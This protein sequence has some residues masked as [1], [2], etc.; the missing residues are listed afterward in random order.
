[1]TAFQIGFGMTPY[2]RALLDAF[3]QIGNREFLAQQMASQ[4]NQQ[5]RE[6]LFNQYLGQMANTTNALDQRRQEKAAI[7]EQMRREGVQ[8]TRRAEDFMLGGIQD[9]R[10]AGYRYAEM[11]GRQDRE[12]ERFGV[13]EERLGS[14]AE[15]DRNLRRERFGFDRNNEEYRRLTGLATMAQQEE[16][17]DLER[18]RYASTD[19]QRKRQQAETYKKL[20]LDTAQAYGDYRAK[21][22]GGWSNI[23]T[24]Q[25]WAEIDQ[26]K[27]EIGT[28]EDPNLRDE[29]TMPMLQKLHVKLQEKVA[30]I[31]TDD[32][33]Q[34]PPEI[35]TMEDGTKIVR[36]RA[37][38]DIKL[39]SPIVER[40][41]PGV[42]RRRDMHAKAMQKWLDAYRADQQKVADEVTMEGGP[43]MSPRDVIRNGMA[44][45]AVMYMTSPDPE[46]AGHIT[47]EMLQAYEEVYGAGAQKKQP[48]PQT[49]QEPQAGEIGS[50]SKPNHRV[51]VEIGADG[52]IAMF[53]GKPYSGWFTTEDAKR[54][55]AENGVIFKGI[56]KVGP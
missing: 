11:M 52:P 6:A 27:K 48:E 32:A 25:D 15:F 45:A 41:E 50:S 3:N 44:D 20:K 33:K 55:Y 49:Q 13:R 46:D 38:G 31:I 35:E 22:E 1:M 56:K 4:S 29:D 16:R 21:R 12:D 23:G 26:L 18:L 28:L 30:N 19:D 34:P 2:D 43:T 36:N 10:Q 54:M 9:Q 53:D 24:P 7:T 40:E 39:H 8:D 5:T 37:T 47:P 51:V 42:K 17:I 14:D